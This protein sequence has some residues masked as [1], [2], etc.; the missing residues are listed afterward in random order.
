MAQR[1]IDFGTFPNDPDADA[2]R[3]AFEKVQLN[4]TE[5]FSGIQDQAVIS[6]NRTPGQ[7]TSVNSPTG[8]VIINA[9]IACVT[10]TTTTLSLGLNGANGNLITTMDN[11][12]TQSLTI[13]LPANITGITNANF[14]GTVTASALVANSS[15]SSSNTITATGNLSAGNIATSGRLDVTGNAA[16]GNVYANAGTI[17]ASLL[18]G[19]LTTAAQPNITTLGTLSN[20]NV[21]GSGN[22]NLGNVAT[23]NFFIG[24]GT[25][26]S[27]VT[28]LANSVIVSGSSQ[29]FVTLNGN[30]TTRITGADIVTVSS[31]GVNTAGYGTFTGN[32][33]SANANLGNAVNA[34]FFIGALYGT[35]NAATNAAAVLSNTSTTTTVYLVGTTN[36]ANANTSLA[37]VTGIYANMANN[38][39]TAT[40]FVGSLSGTATS[41]TNAAALLQNTSTATTVYPTFTAS[42]ANGNS[43]AVINTGISANLA[44]ASIT[45]TT[46]VGALSGNA[47]T[48]GTVV[49][50]A[51]PNITSVGTLTSLAVTGNANVGNLNATSAVTASTLTSNVATG[52]APLTVTSTTRVAN[53]NVA[54]ANVADFISVAAGTGNNFLIFA[55]AATGNVTELTSTGLTAN[56]SN[57]S[58]TATTFVG[59]LSGAATSATTAGTVTT[60]AQ[61]N[62]TSV[63]TLTSLAVTGN[64]TAANF[65]G[66]LAN[67]T[68]D[69][70]IPAA[71]GNINFDVAGNANILVVTGTGAN[72]AGTLNATGNANTGNLGTAQVLATANITAPQLISNIVTGTAPFVV[73]STTQVANLNAATAGAAT[74]ASALLQ[75]TSTA[76]TVYPTFTTSSANGNSSAVINTGISAN[77]ANASIAAT[78]FVGA[79]MR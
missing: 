46:F 51:Q 1:N 8:N 12:T 57:N 24:D 22:S 26:I 52:T 15:I 13:D 20:L 71:N 53:L 45:A 60:N 38:A 37:K 64:V 43:S 17:G 16:A 21:S 28:A 74:N 32:L 65:I 10:V 70:S 33:T 73:T 23:A 6:I 58:I 25:G 41:A 67:G 18:T 66:N 29:V 40:T 4:F 11:S 76:T 77:L 39:I 69:I 19:T 62:I 61:P 42:S 68:S 34:N 14:S 7:G 50:A 2:I 3:T 35:A 27:N 5:L 72:I 55:N 78:T 75:N 49:T 30:V 36:A 59:A 63:G 79:L 48:A 9:D 56:L 47:T 31:A 54:Y 44:N